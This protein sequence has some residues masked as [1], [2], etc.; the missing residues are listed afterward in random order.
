M[1][2]ALHRDRDVQFSLSQTLTLHALSQLY[3]TCRAWRDWIGATPL[4]AEFVL[5]SRESLLELDA[6]DE[7]ISAVQLDNLLAASDGCRN[8]KNWN[9]RCWSSGR[10]EP[11]AQ[12]SG[13]RGFGVSCAALCAPVPRRL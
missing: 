3:V 8:W 12:A 11:A 5:D 1:L 9:C 10:N 4:S 6:T 2:V 7:R 13:A